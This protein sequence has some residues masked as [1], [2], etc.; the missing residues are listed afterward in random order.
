MG[1][2]GEGGDPTQFAEYITRNIHLHRL[3]QDRELEVSELANFTRKQMA[4]FLRSQV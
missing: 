4:D 3:R 1:V 2:V